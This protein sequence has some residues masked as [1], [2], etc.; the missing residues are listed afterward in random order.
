MTPEIAKCVCLNK[1]EAVV[2][3]QLLR[4]VLNGFYDK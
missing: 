4:K 2:F 3:Y 1:E